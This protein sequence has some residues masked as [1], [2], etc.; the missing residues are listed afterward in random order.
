MHGIAARVK[1]VHTRLLPP[2]TEQN[3][4]CERM[5]NHPGLGVG[6]RYA[7]C[8][9]SDTPAQM[10]LEIPDWKLLKVILIESLL[11]TK[12][13]STLFTCSTSQQPLGGGTVMAS[14][15]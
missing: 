8:Y 4:L 5:E 2:A 15:I 10:I 6:G 12:Q 1:P 11:R 7:V 9:V 3:I 13:S 14:V